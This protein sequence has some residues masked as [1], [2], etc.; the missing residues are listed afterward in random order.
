MK[1]GSL[2]KVVIQ[3]WD[4]LDIKTISAG[5]IGGLNCEVPLYL[6]KPFCLCWSAAQLGQL[7]TK[8]V[9]PNSI[10][11]HISRVVSLSRVSYYEILVKFEKYY[12]IDVKLE[13]D[14]ILT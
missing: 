4:H 11:M 1:N 12:F 5:P 2:G 9:F 14:W 8:A 10:S 3:N 7:A 13:N 6:C